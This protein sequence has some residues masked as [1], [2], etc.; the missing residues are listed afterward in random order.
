MERRTERSKR[1]E[2]TGWVAFLQGKLTL[3]RQ[4]VIEALLRLS[5][6]ELLMLVAINMSSFDPLDILII[7]GHR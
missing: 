1:E 2:C 6:L 4:L 5:S 3:K 7:L